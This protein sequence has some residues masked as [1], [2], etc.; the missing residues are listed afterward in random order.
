VLSFDLSGNSGPTSSYVNAGIDLWII[1]PRKLPS[2]T[3][4]AFVKVEKL[5]GGNK[6][7]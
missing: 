7:D 6:L 5:Q 2:P 1:A 4:D 3:K